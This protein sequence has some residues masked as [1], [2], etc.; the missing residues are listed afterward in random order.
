M[1]ERYPPFNEIVNTFFTYPR[2]TSEYPVYIRI[3]PRQFTPV[4]TLQEFADVS[5]KM[6]LTFN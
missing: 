5:Q 3:F 4:K 2:F 1:N 6:G